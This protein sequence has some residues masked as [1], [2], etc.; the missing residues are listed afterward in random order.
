MRFEWDQN[1][2]YRSNNGVGP[3][4]ARILCVTDKTVKMERWPEKGAGRTRFE[5]SIKFFRSP[6][7][8]WRHTEVMSGE[9]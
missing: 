2:R 6:R 8:G 9:Q 3:L 7:C 5:L 4:L 1:D